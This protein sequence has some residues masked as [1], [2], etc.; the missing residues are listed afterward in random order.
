MQTYSEAL[1]AKLKSETLLIEFGSGSSTKTK[2]LLEAFIRVHK[3]CTYMPIDISKEM[4]IKSANNLLENYK[5]LNVIAINST[6]D[7]ALQYISENLGNRSKLLLFLGSSIGNLNLD[8]Q[9]H[10]LTGIKKS[11]AFKQI[12]F[13]FNFFLNQAFKQAINC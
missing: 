12:F 10:F 1:V 11:F 2:V 4:L 5:E 8:E 9:I 6:Y 3:K 13:V 7:D